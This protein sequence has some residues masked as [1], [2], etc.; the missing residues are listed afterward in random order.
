MPR[1]AAVA[2]KSVKPEARPK[3]HRRITQPPSANFALDA[4]AT[5]NSDFRW[6]TLRRYTPDQA[7]ADAAAEWWASLPPNALALAWRSAV[8]R[9]RA[10]GT[11]W[12]LIAVMKARVR[13]DLEFRTGLVKRWL[14]P[15]PQNGACTGPPQPFGIACLVT[16]R[17]AE[18][19]SP[20]PV[21]GSPD[22]LLALLTAERV[23]AQAAERRVAELALSLRAVGA[24][25][26]GHNGKDGDPDSERRRRAYAELARDDALEALS[27]EREARGKTENMLR[28]AT[29]RAEA[30]ARGRAAAERRVAELERLAA[31]AP[32]N[33]KHAAHEMHA[34]PATDA[35]GTPARRFPWDPAPRRPSGSAA[36]DIA[37]ERQAAASHDHRLPKAPS[38]APAP[39]AL[40]A[41]GPGKPD[42]RSIG[43]RICQRRKAYDMTQLELAQAIGVS[44]PLISLWERDR[45][46]PP[47]ERLKLLARML[48]TTVKSLLGETPARHGG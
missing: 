2:P 18:N 22:A 41:P 16:P 4:G 20:L 12:S 15:D 5:G 8:A 42:T 31:G 30:E 14:E 9:M 24:M 3:P 48:H 23:R 25:A 36:V 1:P 37:A 21:P 38:P 45:L 32:Q 17:A 11:E 26:R 13:D 33:G 44:G 34:S 6:P 43:E 28:D 40:A 35:D 10:S 27:I 7:K 19:R 46:R 39:Q 29:R 47:D